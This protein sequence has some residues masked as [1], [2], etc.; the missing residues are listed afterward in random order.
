[1]RPTKQFLRPYSTILKRSLGPYALPRKGENSDSCAAAKAALAA[2]PRE[3]WCSAGSRERAQA[4]RERAWLG[5]HV[6][7]CTSF[8]QE[9]INRSLYRRSKAVAARFLA[10]AAS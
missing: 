4:R 6:E 5:H 8:E 10:R 7:L 1:M 3:A 9:V 2:A